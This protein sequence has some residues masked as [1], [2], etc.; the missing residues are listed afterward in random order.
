MQIHREQEA[1]IGRP[2]QTCLCL[3]VTR[4]VKMRPFFAGQEVKL[5]EWRVE[6]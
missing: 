6:L 2:T 1:E 4:R 5:A 3:P